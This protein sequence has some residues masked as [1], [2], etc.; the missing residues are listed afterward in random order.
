MNPHGDL[1]DALEVLIGNPGLFTW[2]F[3][4]IDPALHANRAVSLRRE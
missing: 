4:L 3:N 1:L 2:T